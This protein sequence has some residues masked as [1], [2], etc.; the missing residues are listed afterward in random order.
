MALATT[1][2]APAAQTQHDPAHMAQT[3]K[4]KKKKR[5]HGSKGK[6]Q[7]PATCHNE[8]RVLTK[9]ASVGSVRD[10]HSL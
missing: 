4:K 9:A 8:R 6:K 2:I 7:R 5:I 3:K 10:P 1:A